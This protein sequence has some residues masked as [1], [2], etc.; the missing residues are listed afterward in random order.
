MA[1]VGTT[2]NLGS[3]LSKKHALIAF[4]IQA[5]KQT[6]A[7]AEMTD[8]AFAE[9]V[10]KIQNRVGFELAESARKTMS[11][12]LDPNNPRKIGQT[13][14]ASQNLFTRSVNAPKTYGGGMQVVWYVYEGNLTK[15]NK[16]IRQGTRS[17]P[18]KS[19]RARANAA[20][21]IEHFPQAVVALRGFFG[22]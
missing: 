13:G 6:K 9:E 11:K 22:H 4:E 21:S 2:R 12:W 3:Y 18:N 17:Y 20:Q 16:F 7:A 15:A 14:K 5:E 8:R 10:G 1:R 19:L